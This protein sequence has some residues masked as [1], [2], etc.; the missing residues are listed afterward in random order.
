[1]SKT[2][3]ILFL[4][5]NVCSASPSTPKIHTYRD[6]DR[7]I[8]QKRAKDLEIVKKILNARKIWNPFR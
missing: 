4:L 7:A 6:L 8:S 3:L 1:M 5:L 2:I